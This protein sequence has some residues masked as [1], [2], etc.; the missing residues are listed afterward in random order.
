M[1]PTCMP[2]HSKYYIKIYI[3][4]FFPTPLTLLPIHKVPTGSKINVCLLIHAIFRNLPVLPVLL[5]L[6]AAGHQHPFSTRRL[7]EAWDAKKPL[8][9][10]FVPLELKTLEKPAGPPLLFLIRFHPSSLEAQSIGL[11]KAR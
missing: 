9:G 1:L 7:H 2:P 10:R 8:C 4:I 6:Q 5:A 11:R 3:Y